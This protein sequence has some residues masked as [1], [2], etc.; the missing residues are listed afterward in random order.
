MLKNKKEH[1]FQLYLPQLEYFDKILHFNQ[2]VYFIKH[3]IL[4]QQIHFEDGWVL[5]ERL[6][7]ADNL[8]LC[9]HHSFS[10]LILHLD[11][12]F[13]GYPTK[14]LN[15][16]LIYFISKHLDRSDLALMENFNFLYV[17][18]KFTLIS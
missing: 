11:L 10:H 9:C 2:M 8:Y 14:N 3:Q 18:C 12:T 4:G 6:I 1:Y 17:I 15:V 16:C 5:F 13:H 7:F